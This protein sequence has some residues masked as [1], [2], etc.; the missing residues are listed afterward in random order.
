MSATRAFADPCAIE[1]FEDSWHITLP[2]ADS[3]AHDVELPATIGPSVAL[4]IEERDVDIEVTLTRDGQFV[5]LDHAVSRGSLQYVLIDDANDSRRIR[6]RARGPRGGGH[7]VVHAVSTRALPRRCAELLAA[8]DDADARYSAWLHRRDLESARGALE[9]YR[10]AF[11]LARRIGSPRIAA[12]AMLASAAVSYHALDRWTDAAAYAREAEQSWQ[13]LDEPYWVARSRAYLAAS[14]IELANRGASGPRAPSR[15]PVRTLA[16]A[17]QLL[18]EVAA[19]HA[20]RGETFEQARQLNNVGLAYFNEGS[21]VEAIAAYERSLPLYRGMGDTERGAQV[22]QNIALAEWGLGHIAQAVER[23]DAALELASD[24][25]SPTHRPTLLNNRALAHFALADYDA[26]LRGHTEALQLARDAG[27]SRQVAQSLYGLGITWDALDDTT[28][29]RVFLE[30]SLELRRSD[31]NADARG[32]FASLRAL[33]GVR[34]R[35]GD[36]A[37]SAALATEALDYATSDTARQRLWI[38]LAVDRAHRE[39]AA[40]GLAALERVMR[41]ASLDPSTQA[42]ALLASGRML[43]ELA[44][45]DDA[46][47][48]L[49]H[50]ARLSREEGSARGEF[51]ALLEVARLERGAGRDSVALATIDAALELAEIIRSQS[52]NPAFRSG[53]MRPLRSAFDLRIELLAQRRR[54]A[55]ARG[56]LGDADDAA[57]RALATAELARAR[58]WMDLRDARVPREAAQ[59]AERRGRLLRDIAGRQFQLDTLRE[60]GRRAE[61][62]AV[63]LARAIAALRHELEML[64]RTE[65]MIHGI[66]PSLVE[67]PPSAA[68]IPEHARVLEYWLGS[69][70]TYAWVID[71]RGVEMFELGPTAPIQRDIQAFDSALRGFQTI[72]VS[73]RMRAASQLHDTL[74]R[75]L[76]RATRG[77][78]T[79]FIAADGPLHRI[80]FA[81]LRDARRN[82][83]L[84][85][86]VDIASIPG[87][88]ALNPSDGKRPDRHGTR[89]LI[90]ADPAYESP[91]TPRTPVSPSPR[92]LRPLP[93]AR[94]EAETIASFYDPSRVDLF[95][96]VAASRATLQRLDLSRYRIVHVAAHA[97][98]QPAL[99]RASAIALSAFDTAGQAVDPWVWARDLERRSFSAEL[100]M[101][102]ACD[103]AGGDYVPGEGLA[104]LQYV[105]LARGADAVAATL[106]SVPDDIAADVATEVHRHVAKRHGSA[107]AALGSTLRHLARRAPTSDPGLWGAWVISVASLR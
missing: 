99:P 101:F 38:H 64:R 67:S 44:R 61:P 57:R 59:D 74:V 7:V 106:W 90:V 72:D 48:A 82:R 84:I 1:R 89:T 30:E 52:E 33:A 100:V 39:G 102:S 104:G 6:I 78:R 107:V 75:P 56:R 3:Q 22:L 25:D 24:S 16:E 49:L 12:R 40:V 46:R 87:L 32:R 79:L 73:F 95:V 5:T 83:F 10:S 9:Q 58:G 88:W 97:F 15:G 69:D 55:L 80:P 19:F 54:E 62:T 53:L 8:S 31:A 45:V 105:T 50:T 37:G 17:R 36:H 66:Q 4:S 27:A 91:A 92:R 29:A 60:Q 43:G 81:A 63:A 23:F 93:A 85:E 51:D 71:S 86:D 20:S 98:V 13:E 103:T 26:A 70:T 94:R 18:L 65:T 68:A 11:D 2:I 42:F 76:A 14:W 21:H 35:S 28:M 34:Q 96:G 47:S 41:D 77:A